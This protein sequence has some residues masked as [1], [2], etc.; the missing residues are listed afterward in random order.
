MSPNRV[1]PLTYRAIRL[2]LHR[3]A[4]LRALSG[5]EVGPWPSG[6]T[7]P[8]TVLVA[9]EKAI[10]GSSIAAASYHVELSDD[11]AVALIAWCH[12]VAQGSSPRDR[13]VLLVAA[14]IIEAAS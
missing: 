12:E 14:D 6:A 4:A 2:I 3:D 7:L 8:L 10:Q 1:V 13:A 9:L 11:D 5:A